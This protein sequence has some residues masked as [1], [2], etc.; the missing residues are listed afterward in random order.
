MHNLSFGGYLIDTPGIKML[1]FNY[2]QPKDIT[3]NFREIFVYSSKCKYSN[4]THRNEPNCAVKDAV[5]TEEISELRYFNYMQ[6]LEEVED[7]NYWERH[8]DV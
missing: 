8:R 3:H 6:L 4:C 7:I 2:L 5:A 1:S